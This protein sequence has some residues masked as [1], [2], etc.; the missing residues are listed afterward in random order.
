MTITEMNER[1]RELGYTDARISE[2]SGVPLSTVRKVLG[3]ITKAPRYDTRHLRKFWVKKRPA[4]AITVGFPIMKQP[5]S[6]M[7]AA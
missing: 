3:G 2:L 4:P 5:P 1:K 6:A 7:T